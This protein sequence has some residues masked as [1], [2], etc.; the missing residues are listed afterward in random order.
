[1]YPC[2]IKNLPDRPVLSRRF[3]SLVGEL[4]RHFSDIYAAICQL[5]GIDRCSLQWPGICHLHNMD[6]ADLEC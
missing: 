1:M 5:H 6:M 3:R 4:P 2:E